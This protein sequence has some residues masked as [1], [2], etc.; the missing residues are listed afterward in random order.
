MKTKLIS[1]YVG[2]V[3][4][5]FAISG[6]STALAQLNLVLDTGNNTPLPSRITGNGAPITIVGPSNPTATIN[7]VTIRYIG[8]ESVTPIVA[9]PFAGGQTA[10][11]TVGRFVVLGDL[12]LSTGQ[13]IYGIGPNLIRLEVGN[14]ANIASGSLISVSGE[15]R[16]G[17]AGGGSGG[18]PDLR[19][20]TDFG[21]LDGLYERNGDNII[22]G[23][24][25]AGGMTQSP[26]VAQG[27]PG[28]TAG[29][30]GFT[31]SVDDILPGT[32]AYAR[33]FRSTAGGDGSSGQGNV[34]RAAGALNVPTGAST[35]ASTRTTRTTRTMAWPILRLPSPGRAGPAELG[36]RSRLVT[37]WP[38]SR[39]AT[40]AMAETVPRGCTARTRRPSS[41]WS[42]PPLSPFVAA[43]VAAQGLPAV[44]AYRAARVGAVGAAARLRT[45]PAE[46]PM[47]IVEGM[48]ESQG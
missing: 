14:N 40:A 2:L 32:N 46:S 31:N 26:P 43:T 34:G 23:R 1:P 47:E 25:G 41:R 20:F 7:G 15:G 3:F 24:G 35:T 8:T 44:M 11:G 6:G 45:W 29:P 10:T 42:I 48:V 4:A 27:S 9:N 18:E 30:L 5:A 21:L 38:L 19:G 13:R 12:N 39:A 37:L 28:Q 33:L 36:G 17:G 22:G 16:M